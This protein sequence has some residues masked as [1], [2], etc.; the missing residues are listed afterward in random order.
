MRSSASKGF[1]LGLSLG[2]ALVFC[3]LGA[4][5]ASARAKKHRVE[6]SSFPSIMVDETQTPVIMKGLERPKRAVGERHHESN[7]AERRVNIPRGSANFVPTGGLPRT[8]LLTQSPAV[9]PYNPPPISNPSERIT[10][11]NHSFPLN[12]G[13]GNNP[14]DRDAYIRYNLNR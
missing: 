14:T 5:Q 6:P 10:Q 2:F 13:L 1:V 8:P 11:F 12:G 3:A 4:Q 7:E 9:T